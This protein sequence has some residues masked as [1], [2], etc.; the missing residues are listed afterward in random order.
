MGLLLRTAPAACKRTEIGSERLR[1]W[2]AAGLTDV[3]RTGGTPYSFVYNTPVSNRNG[4]Y[5]Y[6]TDEAV[7]DEVESRQDYFKRAR[8]TAAIKVLTS[9]DWR[10]GMDFGCGT[11][12]NIPLLAKVLGNLVARQITALDRDGGRLATARRATEKLANGRVQIEYVTGS[13]DNVPCSVAYDLILSC[14]VFPHMP[15][16]EF[17]H[18]IEVLHSSLTTN[19]ILIACVPF[20]SMDLADDF[21]HVINM[22]QA[23]EG[24]EVNR[25]AITPE[26]F[27]ELAAV[28]ASG[29][30]PVRAFRLPQ[31]LDVSDERDLPVVVAEPR[32]FA[33]LDGFRV[34]SCMVYSVHQYKDG[35]PVIGDLILKLRREA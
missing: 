18:T 20:H 8:E 25:E 19:G 4:R 2:G 7:T 1:V 11:G 23:L 17:A 35:K 16:A 24:R 34:V 15:R 30:L 27:D 10:A 29:L 5:H 28:P 32:A 14:Q 21:Y 22:R 6:P 13:V 12:R 31:A 26:R 33:A 3:H 9:F